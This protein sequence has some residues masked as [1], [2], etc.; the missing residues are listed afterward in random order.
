MTSDARAAIVD[1]A[2][3]ANAVLRPVGVRD[4]VL[5]DAFWAPR[6]H[7]KQDDPGGA[8]SAAGGDGASRQL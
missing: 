3:S 6:L 7:A 2:R 4:V 1:T 8:A 5:E